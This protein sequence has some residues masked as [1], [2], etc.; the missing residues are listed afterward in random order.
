MNVLPETYPQITQ[1]TQIT[2]IFL[3]GI[4]GLYPQ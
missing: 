4:G 2:Q 1:I 3:K